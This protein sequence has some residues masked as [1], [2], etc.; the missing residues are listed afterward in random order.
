MNA[1]LHILLP[2][3]NRC[4]TTVRFV[5]ALARQTWCGFHLVLIDDGSTDGTASAVQAVWPGVETITGRG[6]WW[7]A[8]SLDQGCQHLTRVGIADDDVV[9]FI[10]DDVEIGPRFLEDALAEFLPLRDTLLLARQTDAATVAEIDFGGGVRA[11]LARLRFAPTG[12]R[13]EIN[14]LPTRGLFLRWRDY[15]T[16]GG[17]RPAALPH[18]LSDYEFTLRARRAG[19]ALRIAHTATL[20]VHLGRTGRSLA[21]LFAEPRLARFR[22][23]L[24]PRFK[25]NPVVWSRFVGL[26]VPPARRPWLWAK[27]W[28][29]AAV[30]AVRCAALP[31]VS[32]PGAGGGGS[33]MRRLARSIVP[34]GLRARIRRR[35]GWKWFRGDYETWAEARAASHGYDA[36]EILERVL[37]ATLKVQ[38]GEAAFERDS[39]LFPTPE[40]DGPLVGAFEELRAAVGGEMRVLDFGGSLGSVYWRMRPHLPAEAIQRWDVVE[41]AGFVT[42]GRRHVRE[43]RL[44]FF[45]TA[46][47]AEAASRHDVL[48]CATTLQY[49]ESPYATLAE[50][51]ALGIPYLL[52]N[53]LPLHSDG[54]T[55]LRVQW[56][57][58][59][60]YTASYP[61]WFFNR[62]EF[63]ARLAGGYEV[64]REFAGEAVW[65]VDGGMYPSTGLLLRRKGAA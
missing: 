49:L 48:L 55:R 64:V 3:H 51:R 47:E 65:P 42:A 10:N 52:L 37:A 33:A 11:D 61:V 18:Y 9:L 22:L 1:R 15:C 53:N 20:G 43:P 17:F 54:P 30:V 14:C 40:P 12:D 62:E 29:H 16:I 36:G 38:A 21:N 56:V 58:P 63:F 34:A 46:Q 45:S 60:I 44:Q 13:A 41:Q 39:V 8:G 23:L 2:V 6:D 5:E 25:D 35:W 59:A 4:A 27:V 28:A 50:W 57:P 19:L 31:V 26:A 24:S 32:S 7:W